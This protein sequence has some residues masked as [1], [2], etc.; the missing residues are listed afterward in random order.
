[1]VVISLDGNIGA[2]KSTVLHYLKNKYGISIDTEPVDDWIP[3]LHDMYKNN[4]D[5]FEF[6]VK[7][8]LDRVYHTDYPTD[9]LVLTERSGF[10]QWNVFTK[11]NFELGKLN[12]RQYHILQSLYQNRSNPKPDVYIYIQS[13]PSFSYKRIHTRNRNCENS[14]SLTYLEKLHALHE[15]AYKELL[16]EKSKAYLINMEGKSVEEIGNEIYELITPYLHTATTSTAESSAPS[17]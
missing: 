8:W 16:E 12:E 17:C 10:F 2:G 3:F 15:N 9:S 7:V 1:M 6:Q 5:A 14:I 13:N 4:K 11:A